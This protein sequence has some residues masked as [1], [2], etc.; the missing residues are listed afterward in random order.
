MADDLDMVGA[1][2]AIHTTGH[3]HGRGRIDSSSTCSVVESRILDVVR[4]RTQDL[5]YLI[6]QEL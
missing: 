6:R 5:V 3:L 1:R 2:M 4:R